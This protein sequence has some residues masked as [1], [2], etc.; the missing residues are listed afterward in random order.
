[1][2]VSKNFYDYPPD[3]AKQE[4]RPPRAA[5]HAPLDVSILAAPTPDCKHERRPS[6]NA[7]SVGQIDNRCR[8]DFDIIARSVLVRRMR[9][10]RGD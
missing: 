9:S 3:G 5:L 7:D 10:L 1:M 6:L 8:F 4:R 2:K